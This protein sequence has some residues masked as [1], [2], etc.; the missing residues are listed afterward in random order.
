MPRLIEQSYDGKNVR[1]WSVSR[2]DGGG[3]VTVR[4]SAPLANTPASRAA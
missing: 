1:Q 3:Q 4:E 2:P